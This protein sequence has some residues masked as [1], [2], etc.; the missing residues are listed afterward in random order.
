MATLTNKQF[1]DVRKD[2]LLF[3]SW[4]LNNASDDIEDLTQ[5]TMLKVFT[6]LSSFDENRGNFRNWYLTIAN[7]TLK[8]FYR[9][10]KDRMKEIS[11]A[12]FINENG[13]EKIQIVDA[14]ESADNGIKRNEMHSDLRKAIKTLNPEYR[15]VIILRFMQNMSCNEIADYCNI[16]LNTALSLIARG[17][18]LLQGQ[19]QKQ[20]V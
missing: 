3:V 2:V 9:S 20:L 7:N 14:N 17:K 15:K 18:K 8:D 13:T 1:A 10:N 11:V 19:L 4:K 12:D 16:P 5:D 6:S